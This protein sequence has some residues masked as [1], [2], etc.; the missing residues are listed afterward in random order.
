MAKGDAKKEPDPELELKNL[1]GEVRFQVAADREMQIGRTAEKILLSYADKKPGNFLSVEFAQEIRN[2]ALTLY[3]EPI[4]VDPLSVA[5]V[6][7]ET[8]PKP[9]LEAHTEGQ[10]DLDA[11]E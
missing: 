6:P 10:L 4:P 8:E 11:S 3:G 7:P 9:E 2:V 5:D 1:E